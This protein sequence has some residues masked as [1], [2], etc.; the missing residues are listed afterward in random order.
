[1][2][3]A[4]LAWRLSRGQA[5]RLWLLV[6]CV[7]IGVAARVCVGSFTGTVERALA[8]EA[9]P[10]LGGDIEIA[11][12]QP[13]SADK[14]SELDEAMPVGSRIQG[15]L[16]FT[17][18]GSCAE[19]G[20]ARPVEVRAVDPG[21]PF[22]GDIHV[23]D[24]RGEAHDVTPLFGDEALVYV[25][26]E[27][28]PQLGAT[29]GGTLRLGATSFRI[30]GELIDE[31]GLGAN[32]FALGPRVLIARSRAD[33]TGLVG[34]LAR[35]RHVTLVVLPEPA[36][37][38]LLAN[39]LRERWN[40]SKDDAG[41]FGGRVGGESGIAIRTARQAQQ[42]VARTFDRMTDWL[43]LVSL[44]A[45]LLGG[46]G[47]AALVRGFVTEHLDAMATLQVLGAR[48]GLVVRVFLIQAAGVG[49]VGGLIG[50]LI[51]TLAQDILVMLLAGWLP[52]G[53]GLAVDW[54]ALSWGLALSIATAIGFA[55]LPLAAMRGL[56]PLAV[57]RGDGSAGGGLAATA[58]LSLLLL[59]GFMVIAAL[60]ARSWVLGPMFVGILAVGSAINA[61]LGALSLWSIARLKPRLF[62]FGIRHGLANLG[63]P[64][65]RPVAALV[66]LAAAAQL[67]ATMTA[68]RASLDRELDLTG[69][70]SLPGFFA[71]DVQDDQ[72][73][74]FRAL[75]AKEFKLSDVALSPVVRA[76]LTAINGATPSG[77]DDATREAERNRFMRRRE[78]NLSWRNAP[79]E[80][81]EH[82]S[83]GRWMS[84]DGK[85]VE[86][87]L[88]QRFAKNIGAK[89][90]DT[91]AF[92]VQGV[93]VDAVVTSLRTVRWASLRPNFFVL[94]SPHALIG[95]P[96]MWIAAIPQ[97]QPD[98]RARLPGVLAAHFP[99]VT[100][101]D[102]A[103]TGA[104]VTAVIDRVV[105]A[106]RGV[107]ALALVA[108]LAVLIG[109]ALSTARARRTD[110]SLIAVLGG[111]RRTLLASLTAE[112]AVLG[113]V[114]AALGSGQG[115]LHAWAVAAWFE[116]RL[117]VPLG[118]LALLAGG[119]ALAAT[120]AG[121][122]ACR[123]AITAPPLAVLRDE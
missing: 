117:T 88:E 80:L 27:L 17:T 58:A 63:R 122:L 43:R 36:G 53:S 109:V 77:G 38:E 115:V 22:A 95:A 40:I 20:R 90:G 73:D 19:N 32:P 49:V 113:L 12:N 104:R 86:C 71:V 16:H 10:L 9:R 39:A 121:V 68:H 61:G 44:I 18:M 65:F 26:R 66:A 62:G 107:A 2:L 70:S 112:F 59:A 102:I 29:R 37:T 14:R 96:T 94:L 1:M 78:Q 85:R 46:I 52:A 31:P 118:E 34:T 105:L 92:D 13:L 69:R 74:D 106:V 51:G 7:A 4:R 28:L 47:V 6:A 54:R 123:Q 101:F 23:A 50:G 76:R 110:A 79:D 5:A 55:A 119:I 116:L 15:Q 72:V 98:D 41:G 64:G 11:A 111:G 56:R 60:E 33:G 114:A 82:I 93:P 57:M 45:L 75:L 21:H 8:R 3:T 84:S 103:D 67:L 48:P 87:S 89:L 35:V 83:A 99:N 30:A 25:Q 97:V 42:S 120:I 100:A 81:A 108:G 91:L 24:Q